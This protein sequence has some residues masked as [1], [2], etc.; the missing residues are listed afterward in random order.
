MISPN[1][2]F[3]NQYM[4]LKMLILALLTTMFFTSKNVDTYEVGVNVF[5]CKFCTKK[6]GHSKMT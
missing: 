4:A 2:H 1:S 5:S 3:Q 6:C